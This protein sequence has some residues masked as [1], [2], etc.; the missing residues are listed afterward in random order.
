VPMA[1][2]LPLQLLQTAGQFLG[3]C[4]R[5]RHQHVDASLAPTGA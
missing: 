1:L 4:R 5:R 2:P 3:W